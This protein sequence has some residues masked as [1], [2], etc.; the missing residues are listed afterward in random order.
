MP[1]KKKNNPVESIEE[2]I[3][4]YLET[5]SLSVFQPFAGKC[6]GCEPYGERDLGDAIN[7]GDLNHVAKIIN[8]L[9]NFDDTPSQNPEKPKNIWDE[10]LEQAEKQLGDKTLESRKKSYINDAKKA[11]KA[12][13][14]DI[15]PIKGSDKAKQDLY[16]LE[17]AEQNLNN[18]KDE[19]YLEKKKQLAET[20]QQQTESQQVNAS[21]FGDSKMEISKK[22]LTKIMAAMKTI[23]KH[24]AEEEET[25]VEDQVAEDTDTGVEEEEKEVKTFELPADIA[26]AVREALEEGK[27]EEAEDEEDDDEEEDE[28]VEET[29]S[30]EEDF[31]E[32]LDSFYQ[33]SEALTETIENLNKKAEKISKETQNAAEEFIDNFS[34]KEFRNF[35]ESVSEAL[36][37]ISNRVNIL[38]EKVAH[39]DEITTNLNNLEQTG[40]DYEKEFVTKSDEPSTA[41]EDV[42]VQ[43]E[44]VGVIANAQFSEIEDPA[45]Y[46]KVKDFLSL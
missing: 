32:E 17:I 2:A 10:D 31:S 7:S 4:Q 46:D 40:D 5:N 13:A 26:D 45:R 21:E 6:K 15:G 35:A 1:K 34:M 23:N 3:N 16:R 18:K 22:D 8:E 38:N 39:K 44:D 12:A 11:A 30:E 25:E 36:E 9:S 24:F 20:Y 37:N 27:V 43:N 41:A 33:F 28:E 19:A 14:K 42:V 29:E